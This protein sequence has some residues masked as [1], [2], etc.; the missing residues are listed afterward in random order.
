MDRVRKCLP[1]DTALVDILEYVHTRR[2]DQGRGRL[3]AELRLVAVVV[4][5]DGPIVRVD[6]GPAACVTEA[7][8]A[9]LASKKVPSPA[10]GADLSRLVWQ[11]LRPHLKGART[12]L[13][14]P[15][16]A[17]TGFPFAALPGSKPG[18]YL[19]EERGEPTITAVTVPQMLPDLLKT[20]TPDGSQNLPSLLVVGGVDYGSV[21]QVDATD[22]ITKH[23]VLG[24]E[25]RNLTG[26]RVEATLV[27][28]LFRE[29]HPMAKDRVEVLK[30]DG[31]TERAI[32]DAMPRHRW[33][34][35]A[36]HGVYDP[37]GHYSGL[38]P[39]SDGHGFIA[40]RGISGI[41]PGLLS[42]LVL[43]GANNPSEAAGDDSFLTALEVE[44]L[45]L[46]S[47]DLAVLSACES[48]L[49]T[50][51]GGEGLLG[52]QRA[53]HV[54]GARTVVAS[55]WKVPDVM[56]STLMARFYENLWVTGKGKGEALREAQL[57]L[58]H[59]ERTGL[60]FDPERRLPEGA[61]TLPP[62]SW[63]AF[64]LSGDWR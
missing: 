27:S 5:R 56:T 9:W 24:R 63:A 40:R 2:P 30:E 32:R 29:T 23:P 34:H 13:I 11:P 51:I 20:P 62:E 14:S 36:T 60:E 33:I 10:A 53:F 17:L 31:A 22:R 43:A 37:E 52:L 41:H 19:I 18:S 55:F 44:T 26:G 16:G 15:D 64:S 1:A 57:W 61:S 50:P 46:H 4:R 58:L 45:D 7:V 21:R 42:G 54:A 59:G 48:G 3:Q 49:G 38:G 25:W 47:V 35:L 8:R 12:V 6:L 39:V 28:D